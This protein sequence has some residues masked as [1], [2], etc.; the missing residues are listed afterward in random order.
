[1]RKLQPLVLAVMVACGLLIASPAQAAISCSVAK[2]I[3]RPDNSW[4]LF[5]NYSGKSTGK[6]FS[7]RTKQLAVFSPI[8][9]RYRTYVPTY[10][11]YTTPR[12]NGL[13]LVEVRGWYA[14]TEC[15][16]WED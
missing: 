12:L 1:M 13:A 7:F 15:R 16:K 10:R 9:Y 8:N 3:E 14:G 2:P 4:S 5:I 11:S 6:A